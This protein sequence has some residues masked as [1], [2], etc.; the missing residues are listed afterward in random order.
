MNHMITKINQ[1]GWSQEVK[2]LISIDFQNYSIN[3]HHFKQA[4]KKLTCNIVTFTTRAMC[5]KIVWKGCEKCV[6]KR[7]H[8]KSMLG[9]IQVHHISISHACELFDVHVKFCNTCEKFLSYVWTFFPCILLHVKSFHTCETILS[10]MW[11]SNFTCIIDAMHVK[12]FT[13]MWTL[14]GMS[15]WACEFFSGLVKCNHYEPYFYENA[16]NF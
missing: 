3:Y 16:M 12:F 5:V 9:K 14:L 2:L 6:K 10:C 15:E 4:L 1:D 7:N 13:C 8:V 11:T